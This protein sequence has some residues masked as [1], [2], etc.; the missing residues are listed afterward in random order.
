MNWKYIAYG[1]IGGLVFNEVSSKAVKAAKTGVINP[2]GAALGAGKSMIKVG[3][4]TM[5]V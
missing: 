4:G 1:G 5:R 3:K 2:A